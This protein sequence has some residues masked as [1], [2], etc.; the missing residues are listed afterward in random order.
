MLYIYIE[1]LV[2]LLQL[3]LKWNLFEF[4]EKTFCQRQGTAMGTK[5]APNYADIVMAAMDELIL[6][7]AAKYGEG[8]FPISFY[9]RFLDDI[10]FIFMG[11]HQRLHQFLNELNQLHP[12]IKFTISHTKS[13]GACDTCDCPELEKIPFLDTTIS[14]K[15]NKIVTDL[16]RKPSDR[17]Q[18]LLPSSCHPNHCHTN[19]PYSL[20]L[21]IV[22]ICS[23]AESRDK[24]FDELRDML[25]SRNYQSGLIASA[26]DR[27]KQVPR[28]EALKRVTKK[29]LL[30]D[31][32][33]L[34]YMTLVCPAWPKLFINTT[35]Q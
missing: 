29:K 10:F 17:V 4:D 33:F 5:L 35:E 1:F 20:A 25:K 32:Y 26:I 23:E 19:I 24:R 9:K 13:P 28:S 8:V 21:R 6:S 18:Y 7:A 34:F 12:N 31:K 16:Y 15:N 2:K 30:K 22:W 14:V 27:A 3:V 11:N